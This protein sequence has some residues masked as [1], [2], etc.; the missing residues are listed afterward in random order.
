MKK[1]REIITAPHF[2]Y[3]MFIQPSQNS[4]IFFVPPFFFK[5]YQLVTFALT[6]LNNLNKMTISPLNKLKDH[7]IL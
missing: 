6:P 4:N 7:F 5:F 2:F 1:E 3:F